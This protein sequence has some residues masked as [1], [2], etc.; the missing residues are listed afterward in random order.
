MSLAE[1]QEI[2]TSIQAKMLEIANTNPN[3]LSPEDTADDA[4]ELAREAWQDRGYFSTDVSSNSKTLTSNALV[5]RIAVD[6]DVEAGSQYVLREIT[7]KDNNAIL[8]SAYLRRLFPIRPGD[9]FSREKV[10]SGLNNLR[11]AYFDK[12]YIN[13]APIPLPTVDDQNRS[14]SLAIDIDEGRQFRISS[15]DFLGIDQP[16]KDELLEAFPIGAVYKE[17]AFK[18]FVDDYPFGFLAENPWFVQQ[19]LDERNG[20]VALTLDACPCVN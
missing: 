9:I 19:H 6:L 10:A 16:L 15:V 3:P 12:G 7:F 8:D 11:D 17:H 5:Q 2:A 13:F 14:V 18:Q 20:A 1:Q 4:A